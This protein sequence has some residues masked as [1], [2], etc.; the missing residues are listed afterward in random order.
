MASHEELRAVR[1]QKKETLLSKGIEVYPS[2][3]KR[4]HEIKEVLP[5]FETLFESKTKI[6]VAGRVMSKRGQGA[7]LFVDVFDGT[8]KIQVVFKI[9]NPMSYIDMPAIENCFEL[10]KETVDV[11][12][13]IE[14]EGGEVS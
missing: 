9:D 2:V 11:G 13:F 1:L 8:G 4:T 5:Q 7:I 12:D 10:C 6:I 14:V 3:S